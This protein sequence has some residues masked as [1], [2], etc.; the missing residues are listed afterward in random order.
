MHSPRLVLPNQPARLTFLVGVVHTLVH[1]VS[2]SAES[3]RRDRVWRSA[4]RLEHASK[5]FARALV[6]QNGSELT[7]LALVEIE[8]TPLDHSGKV[9]LLTSEGGLTM[10]REKA[11]QASDPAEQGAKN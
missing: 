6:R 11:C 8:S 10:N 4:L 2:F 1:Q 7:Q 5:Q 3:H 9:S